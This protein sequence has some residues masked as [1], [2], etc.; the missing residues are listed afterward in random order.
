MRRLTARLR[1]IPIRLKLTLVF[2][3]VMALLL[4][5]LGLF[6]YFHFESG[7]D[8]TLNQQLRARASEV[9]GLVR[10]TNLAHAGLLGERG[11]NFAQ[12]LDARGA[13]IDAAPGLDR[14]Q[15]TSTEVAQARR[16]AILIQRN[17]RTRLYAMPI[18]HGSEIVVVGVSL[19]QHES[20]LETL[21]AALLLGGP[22][23]L[24]VASVA[25]YLLAAAALRPVES[26]RQRA[27]SIS[28]GDIGARLP[29]PDSIDEVHRLG[30]TL[31]EM[32]AR[33]EQGLEHERGFVAD[34]SHE[35]RSP[36]AVLK[37]ELEVALLENGGAEGW[38][39]AVNSAV[40]ETDRIAA[41]ADDLLVLATAE[42]G[43][44]ALHPGS[45]PVADLIKPVE[46]RYAQA[47]STAG[48]R[49]VTDPN[50]RA[51]VAGDRTRLEQAL[52]NLVENA[53]RYG[54]GT[55]KVHTRL[56][57]GKV[58]LHVAD[59]GD[60]FPPEFLPAAFER[61][62]RADPSRPRGGVGLGLAIV[63]AIA[64]AHHGQVHAA[65]RPQGG[66]DV[67]ITLPRTDYPG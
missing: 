3:G 25:G 62:T 26:M 52:S 14:P 20:A 33:L 47:A 55:I 15:L 29:L 37:S 21:G 51:A 54:R 36:L 67:W 7:L 4:L 50:D 31:N 38:R 19:A 2:T 1:R 42:R 41:L 40:E 11:E 58:E 39:A 48:R 17:E 32:L 44:L 53:L 8:G 12:L 22:L 56:A 23:A 30:S 28:S 9:A 18:N 13:V 35:L 34:A 49:I 64:H 61:F 45:L 60:G 27:A 10:T 65:N 24:L 57:D 59:E 5:G 43:L 63:E 16:H 46:Q 66:A 6:L